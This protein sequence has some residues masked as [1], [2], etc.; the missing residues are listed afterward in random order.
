MKCN[1]RSVSVPDRLAARLVPVDELGRVLLLHG[2]DPERPEHPFWFTV[3]GQLEPGESAAEAAA[4]EAHEEVGL[5]VDPGRLGA[6]AW[7][8]IAEFSWGGVE[9]RN[10]QDFFVLRVGTFEPTHEGMDALER[11]TIDGHRW[12]PL[13]ELAAHQRDSTGDPAYPPD[14]AEQ[15]SRVRGWSI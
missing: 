2:I 8:G 15:L 11:E 9:I 7:S 13:A 4:R 6:V 5:A 3:G 1:D 14:L 12:W 10:V